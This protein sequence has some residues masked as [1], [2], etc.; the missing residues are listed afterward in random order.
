MDLIE[1]KVIYLVDDP[2]RY[3][4]T[5]CQAECP[6]KTHL[7]FLPSINNHCSEQNSKTCYARTNNYS[8]GTYSQ[9]VSVYMLKESMVTF[10]VTSN[11]TEA[12]QL[13]ITNDADKCES[14]FMSENNSQSALSRDCHQLT[15]LNESSNYTH[16][17]TAREDGYYCAVWILNSKDQRFN[18]RTTSRLRLYSMTD[19]N[20][21]ST[22][23]ISQPW[24]YSLQSS[25]T[26][27]CIIV[28]METEDSYFRGNF[29]VNTA[30]KKVINDTLSIVI[31]IVTVILIVF[32]LLLPIF[33][34]VK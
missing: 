21:C 31:M 24:T 25:L 8:T 17:F 4:L 2:G 18:Y 5:I 12:L 14:V 1:G 16:I 3:P 33:V 28:H 26:S 32:L 23:D 7:N 6:L 15:I 20:T 10:K 13:C 9:D 19:Y 30:T 34:W 29:T 27:R 11:M 22:F